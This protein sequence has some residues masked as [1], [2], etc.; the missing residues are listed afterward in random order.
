M[1]IVDF[2]SGIGHRDCSDVFGRIVSNIC[3]QDLNLTVL[4]RQFCV[5]R[6]SAFLLSDLSKINPLYDYAGEF[7][8]IHVNV[9]VQLR[10]CNWSYQ[11][12]L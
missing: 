12:A 3:D 5:P 9:G 7:S 8:N 2:F 6:G 11:M 1:S 4:G 10:I